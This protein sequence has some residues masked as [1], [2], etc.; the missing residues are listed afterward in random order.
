MSRPMIDPRTLNI[1]SS[2][3]HHRARRVA[4]GIKIGA[5]ATLVCLLSS[6]AV[7]SQTVLPPMEPPS[8]PAGRTV[9]DSPPPEWPKRTLG[10][11]GAPNV[12]VILT[13][14]IG[15][16]SS[17]AFG[18]LIPTPTLETLA[19]HGI[20]YNQFNTTALCS[21]T[22]ASL[23]T[24]REPHT[25]GMGNVNNLATAYEGYT[26]VMP[27][28]AAMISETLRQNGFSTAA[29][30]KWHLTPEW[31]QSQV[32]PFDHWAVGQG[33]E[34]FYGFDGG[35]TDQYA[36]ALIENTKP[37]AP[38]T[39]DPTYILDRDLADHA[40]GWLQQQH[41]LAPDKPFF[42]YYASGSAH[43]PHSAPKEWRDKFRGKFDQGW[44]QVRE[45]IFERQKTMGVIPAD[46]KLT[47]RPDFLPPWSSLTTDQKRLYAR[48]MEVY[49][50]AVAY[51]DHEIG[52]VV[53]SLRESGQLN[54]TLVIFVEGD[55]GSSA[56]GGKQGLFSETAMINGFEENFDY[57]LAHIDDL[58]TD[59]AYDH[60][61]AAWA[62]AMDT[63]FQ[64]YKQV[65]SH[66]GGV[67]NG[68]V[69]SWPARIKDQGTLRSQFEYVA[70]VVPT[71]LE[72]TGVK[73][74]DVV[75][76]VPQKPMDGVSFVYTFDHPQEPSRRHTQVFEM[77]Q[78]LGIYHDGWWA[79]TTPAAAPWDI[80]L[81]RKI[82]LA[83]RKWELYDISK[84]FSQADDLAASHPDKLAQMK[85]LF[86]TEAAKAKI[87]PIHSVGDGRAGRPSLAEG[88]TDFLFHDGLTRVPEGAAPRLIGHSYTIS[89]KVTCPEGG[90]AGVLIAQ[91][92]RF[93]GWSF[94][95]KNGRPTFHYN[96][97]DERQYRIRAPDPLTRGDHELT[98]GFKADSPTP[99]TGGTMTLAV[100]GR[101]VASGRIE[102]T[103]VT[104]ISNSEGLDVGQDTLTPVSD[105]YTVADSRFTGRLKEVR[106]KLR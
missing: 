99:G 1:R 17:S 33:F 90:G 86:F 32:G 19:S 42:L 35:D 66:F 38:P 23:L 12:L 31:E 47:P 105:D 69:V 106:V 7:I 34:Y 45:E 65:A 84:D 58:G 44:D 15:F 5:C 49:A 43:S 75:N 10:P 96:A 98:A 2:L 94:Y 21:P 26:S 95:L 74:P 53:D 8:R 28:S 68:M 59:K 11:A 103:H 36:P 63:P 64:Y 61:P 91:G 60:Y 70:D 102:H 56:E 39:G 46:A 40:I 30:G 88:R 82:D 92:G 87:L 101:T 83:S 78:N 93:G 100:D 50:A 48:M 27:K 41:D 13:D 76:G 62:W 22:R 54:N 73:A 89:A 51:S 81:V 104:W 14:D 85:D 37:I 52:R 72:A 29:F 24:G 79:G 18:G 80:T 6:T 3:G 4:A 20:K 25:A 55:N 97:I 9:A 16:G 57:L 67:R 71:I 77:V